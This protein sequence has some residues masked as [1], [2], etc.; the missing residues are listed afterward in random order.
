MLSL[1]ADPPSDLDMDWITSTF[2][3]MVSVP[4]CG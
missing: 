4:G 2:C 3:F 1:A